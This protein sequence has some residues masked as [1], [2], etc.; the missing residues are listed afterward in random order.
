MELRIGKNLIGSG[1]K[2][3]IIAELSAN[4]NGSLESALNHV[5]LAAKAGASA[6]KLQTYTADTMT[7]NS[8]NE[9]FMIRGGLW[10][11]YSLYDLYEKAH[12]P[13]EW[14]KEIFSLANELGVDCFSSPFDE[15]AVDFLEELGAP[16][17]KIASFEMI[18]HPLIEKIA[19]TGKP[20]IMST[21][22]AT[23]SEVT[24][25]VEVIRKYHNDFIVLHCVSGYPTPIDQI[26]LKTLE[27]LK[28]EFNCLVGLSDHT[29]SNTA[30]ICS[31]ALGACV[32]EKHFIESRSL[33]GVDSAFS[34]EPSE[35][36]ELVIRAK[37][38]WLSQG[39]GSFDLK[40][41]EKD[42]RQFRRSIY[43]VKDLSEGEAL[44]KEHVKRIRPGY[45]L[46]PKHLNSIIGKK[47]SRSVKRGEP[48]TWDSF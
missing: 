5:R 3:Y 10:D 32:I 24:E 44:K 29:L 8:K 11:G 39:R 23:L 47:V 34:I 45:G 9:E 25:A 16:A 46:A 48:V 26:N 22:M 31:V 18:D 27:L 33:G 14:H 36:E 28:S 6:I 38:A 13:W 20:I 4:H 17:Y 1:H 37:E 43:F 42:N 12:T 30:A 2:P 41:A 35:L 7:I 40:N 21:G 15:S 19:K